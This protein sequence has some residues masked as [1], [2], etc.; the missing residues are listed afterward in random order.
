VS[1]IGQRAHHKFFQCHPVALYFIG[2]KDFLGESL[3]PPPMV[4]VALVYDFV[5]CF[6]VIDSDETNRLK[7]T[8]AA[9]DARTMMNSARL[10]G[11]M[12][13][14][15]KSTNFLTSSAR[16]D[17]RL[18]DDSREIP[19]PRIPDSPAPTPLRK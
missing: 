17:S 4:I 8:P 1:V 19:P 2:N 18:T 5:F 12:S 11:S 14:L 6:C 13:D 7:K 16:P 9:I 3:R 15:P 10:D